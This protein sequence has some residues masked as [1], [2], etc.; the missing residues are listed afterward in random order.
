MSGSTLPQFHEAELAFG[1]S[2]ATRRISVFLPPRFDREA[3]KYPVVFCSDGGSV[4]GFGMRLTRAMREQQIPATILVGVHN[5]PDAR[6]EEY[7]PGV[8]PQ[9]FDAHADFFAI[10]VVN[11]A[12]TELGLPTDPQSTAVFGVSNGGAF[13]VAMG[14]LHPGTFGRVIAFSVSKSVTSPKLSGLPTSLLPM[15]YLSAGNDGREKA[16]CRHTAALARLMQRHQIDCTYAA[17]EG[18]HEFEFWQS[19]LPAALNWAFGPERS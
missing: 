11:W 8:D 14:L 16:F 13:A 17:R 1:E 3:G 12:R 2:A 18:G 10:K 15:F 9:R 19:E 5:A 7:L 4:P 6:A